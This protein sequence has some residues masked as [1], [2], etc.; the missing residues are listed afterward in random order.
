MRKKSFTPVAISMVANIF[1]AFY[2]EFVVYRLM[3]GPFSTLT[4]PVFFLG[5]LQGFLGGFF[6][7]MIVP[8]GR[9][10]E[11]FGRFFIRDESKH[12]L[13]FHIVSC[14]GLALVMVSLFELICLALVVGFIPMFFLIYI[15]LWWKVIGFGYIGLLFFFP[16]TIGI[17]GKLC[18]KEG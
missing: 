3:Q 6:L 4:A 5:V 17:V 1:F 14:I 10:K 12:G 2:F 8:L 16:A 11:G 9:I 13:G 15:N 7:G 18:V